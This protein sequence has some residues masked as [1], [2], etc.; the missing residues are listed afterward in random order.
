MN[1]TLDVKK[2][3]W[4]IECRKGW[5]Q[6]YENWHKRK[7][8]VKTTNSIIWTVTE[9]SR[10][11]GSIAECLYFAD[12]VGMGRAERADRV[13][14]AEETKVWR[15]MELNILG[16]TY[17]VMEV[18][19]VDKREFKFGEIDFITNEIRIDRNLPKTLKNQTLMH[20]IL[21]AIFQLL[22]MEKEESEVQSLATA[23]HQVF[24]AQTIFSC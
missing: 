9:G 15:S 18:D 4:Y 16:V 23:L 12:I 24:T 22:G 3:M 14:A 2:M 5:R 6:K 8:Y 20:E 17:K 11:L 13:K 1:K 7:I 19:V 10:K 21:H